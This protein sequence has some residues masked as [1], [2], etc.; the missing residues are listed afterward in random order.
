MNFKVSVTLIMPSWWVHRYFA[1]QLGINPE[2]SR[3][4]DEI[5]DFAHI[6]PDKYKTQYGLFEFPSKIEKKHDWIKDDPIEAGLLFNK[7]FGSEALKAM[8]LHLI[9]D[10]LYEGMKK[11]KKKFDYNISFKNILKKFEKSDLYNVAKDIVEFLKNRIKTV[12]KMIKTDMNPLNALGYCDFCGKESKDLIHCEYCGKPF[13]GWLWIL[14]LEKIRELQDRFKDI[15]PNGT[16]KQI[17]PVNELLIIKLDYELKDFDEGTIVGCIKNKNQRIEKIGRV[18]HLDEIDNEITVDFSEL[19][20]PDLNEGDRI[21]IVN[22]ESLIGYDLQQAWILEAQRDFKGLYDIIAE[23]LKSTLSDQM[24][25]QLKDNIEDIIKNAKNAIRILK[26]R[27]KDA[28]TPNDFKDKNSLSGFKLDDSQINIIKQILGLKDNQILIVV[29]PPGTGKTEVIAKAAYEL[30]KRGEKVLITSH[31]NIAVDNALEKLMNRGCKVIRVGRHDKISDKVKE[32]LLSKIRYEQSSNALVSRI[33][34]LE[35]EIRELKKTLRELDNIEKSLKNPKKFDYN[36]IIKNIDNINRF[37]SIKPELIEMQK[38]IIEIEYKI[39]EKEK[40]SKYARSLTSKRARFQAKY[41]V[42]GELK[43]LRKELSK[44]EKQIARF[45]GPLNKILSY[46]IKRRREELVSKKREL[47]ELIERVDKNVLRSADVV[48]STIIRSHLGTLFDITFDTVIIDECS[49][50]SIPLGLMGLIKGKKWVVIGDHLQLLPIF[51]TIKASNLDAH[52]KVS[53]FSTLIRRFGMDAYLGV[54]Y[55]SLPDIIEFS[56]E[57]IYKD[58]GINIEVS[59][60]SGSVCEKFE[61]LLSTHSINYLRYPVI[62]IHINGVN[63]EEKTEDTRIYYPFKFGS[64]YNEEE[65]KVCQEIVK[66]LVNIGVK[67]ERIGIIAPYVAQVKKLKEKLKEIRNIDIS[68]IEINTVDSFQGREKDIIIFSV[69]GTD[70]N[71]INFASNRNRLNVALTRAKCRLIVVGNAN[72]IKNTNT[73]LKDFLEQIKSKGY[74]FD[75][76]NK[77]WIRESLDL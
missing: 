47:K 13:P 67:E 76:D 7:F 12:I 30:V 32:I 48:G 55:R 46:E 18:I 11:Y 51:K 38:K 65:I 50:I 58:K 31:T 41:R 35:K 37:L 3:I 28:I 15:S 53:I 27:K 8:I 72:A 60:Y 68:N 5:I 26:Q 56:K 4:V 57:F 9:L 70:K 33:R 69:T 73:L 75:W 24:K 25:K 23:I 40:E 6:L 59:K 2:L 39:N 29:G 74:L 77:K 16:I 49:Q 20:L 62:F 43:E 63:K 19:K 36:E 52:E 64:V 54:H 71:R 66:T 17:D 61:S 1:Q 22:A 42:E 34:E 14:H 10:N 45:G 21:K 44:Y